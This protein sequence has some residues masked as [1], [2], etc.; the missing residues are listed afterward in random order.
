MKYSPGENFNPVANMK[1]NSLDIRQIRN[2]S[3][4]EKTFLLKNKIHGIYKKSHTESCFRTRSCLMD[5]N[6][7][8]SDL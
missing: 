4:G 7:G 2:I 6:Q 3:K 1:F 8:A 5:S